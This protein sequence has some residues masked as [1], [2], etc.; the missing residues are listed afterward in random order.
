MLER[1]Q[2]E[3]KDLEELSKSEVVAEDV[4]ALHRKQIERSRARILHGKKTD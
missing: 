1:A 2:A 3:L 4:M